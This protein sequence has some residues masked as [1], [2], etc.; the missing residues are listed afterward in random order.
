MQEIPESSDPILS[1]KRTTSDDLISRLPAIGTPYLIWRKLMDYLTVFRSRRIGFIAVLAV[2]TAMALVACADEAADP[3]ATTIPVATEAPAP[4]EQPPAPTEIPPTETPDDAMVADDDAMEHEHAS[5]A[6]ANNSDHGD[7]LTD[8]KGMTLY[9]FDRDTEGV[10]NCSGGCLN[11]WPPFIVDETPETSDEIT[12]T[13]G[14]IDLADGTR[15]VTV[16]GFPAYYWQGDSVEGDTAGNGVNNAWWVFNTDGTPQRP[17][18]VNVSADAEMGD[19]LVAGNGLTLYIFDRDELEK[20]NCS[21]GC[22][23]NWPPLLSEYGVVASDD[24][25]ATIST[26]GASDGSQQITVNGFPAYYWKGDVAEGDTLGNAVGNV[27]WVFNP[28]GTPQRPAKVGLG[29]HSDLGSILVDGAGLSLYLFDNDTAGVSN[30]SGGC[31]TN[32]PPLLTEYGTAALNDVT[33]TLGSI[34]RDDGTEQVTVNDMPVYYW[35][36]D[37]A[38]G[39]ALGQAIGGVWWVLDPAGQAIRN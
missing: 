14:T 6:V 20:S 4:T 16:N 2:M 7:I 32:W 28:D 17:A 23:D 25:T 10:T 27:W 11:A 24:V 12:A 35:L 5:V 13:I 26:I 3:T 34:T 9:I 33:A 30:C 38:T 22:L 15:Q 29:E 36:G 1:P 8:S 37:T 31:L 21:G 19:I 18:K 39:E